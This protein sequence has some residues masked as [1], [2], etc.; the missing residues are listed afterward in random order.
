[1]YIN[2]KLKLN[3]YRRCAIP[4]NRDYFARFGFQES[5]ANLYSGDEVAP[6]PLTK[7][8]AIEDFKH[9]ADVKASEES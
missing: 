9:Y 8:E 2:P 6:E 3:S 7:I 4:S 5:P 1:M